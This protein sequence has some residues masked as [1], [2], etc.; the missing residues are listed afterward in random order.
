MGPGFLL[1]VTDMAEI[2][3]MVSEAA[4][5]SRQQPAILSGDREIIYSEYDQYVAGSLDRLRKAGCRPEDRVA[6]SMPNS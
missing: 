6:V 1:K 2:R 4:Q 5:A 3:C